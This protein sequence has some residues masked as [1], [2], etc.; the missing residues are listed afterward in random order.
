MKH[1]HSDVAVLLI[2][3]LL[4]ATV[5]LTLPLVSGETVGRTPTLT[6]KYY[7]DIMRRISVA[8]K[9]HIFLHVLITNYVGTPWQ[10]QNPKL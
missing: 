1:C 8:R 3:M 9:E 5:T 4:V 6:L 10:Q 7:T 2:C